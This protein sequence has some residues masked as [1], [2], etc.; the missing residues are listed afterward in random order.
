MRWAV[1]YGPD[2]EYVTSEQATPWSIERRGGVQVIVQESG[3]HK[4]VTKCKTDYYVW[5]TRGGP[6]A[7]FGADISGLQQYLMQPG[8][9]CVLFG[10]EIDRARFNEIF[11][12]ARAEFGEKVIFEAD[13]QRPD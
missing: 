11:D 4:W 13:E 3:E 1:Y 7:W 6:P 2:N 5:D 12:R 8:H 10:Y 9:K